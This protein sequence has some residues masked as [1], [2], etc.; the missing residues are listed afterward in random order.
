MKILVLDEWIPSIC[1]SG[2]SIRTF[3]LLSPLAKRHSIT[4]LVNQ[5]GEVNREHLQKMRDAGFDVICVPRPLIYDSIPAIA[6][7]VIPAF[8]DSLPISVRRHTSDEFTK[9]LKRLLASFKFDIVH[10]EWSHYAVYSSY[11]K[12]MPTFACTHNVEY[13]SWKRFFSAT[14]NPFKKLLGLHEWIKMY[15]FEKNYYPKLDYISTV[16]NEDANLMRDKLGMNRVCV[17][18]NGVAI[19]RYDEIENTPIQGKIVYCGSMDTHVNQD[20]VAYFLREIFPLVIEINPSIR[21]QVIGRNPPSWLLKFSSDKVSFTGSIA[22]VRHPLKE[23]MLEVVP[24]RIAGGSRLKIL[25]AFAAKTPVLSTTI[26]AEGIECKPNEN[27]AIADSTV[28]FA[29]KCIELLEDQSLRNKLIEN[30]RK[31]VDEKY[32]WSRISPMVES[33]WNKTI[34]LHKREK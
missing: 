14:Q 15:K 4:Y 32:D 34:E 31:L 2:K 6:F 33:A 11:I 28:E 21:F 8:F 22:D 7:G 9:V 30:G 13:L 5:L 23:A 16:S 24:L 3:E 18:P 1:N 27:I 17:I 12:D 29:A 19:D 10:I 26:G 25:E 20:A